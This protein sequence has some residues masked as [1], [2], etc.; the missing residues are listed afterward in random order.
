MHAQCN[1]GIVETHELLFVGVKPTLIPH[2]PSLGSMGGRNKRN[3]FG[4]RKKSPSEEKKR[5]E[6]AF[7]RALSRVAHPFPI[8][9]NSAPPKTPINMACKQDKCKSKIEK[10]RKKKNYI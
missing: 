10:K 1:K 9:L 3:M 5:K 4:K 7:Y 8:F 2:S 6:P